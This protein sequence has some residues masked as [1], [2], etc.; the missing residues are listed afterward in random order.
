M[1]RRALV[2]S[3]GAI[4]LSGAAL[5]AD[6]PSYAPPPVYLPPPGL[7]LDRNLPRHQCR[8]PLRAD[9]RPKSPEAEMGTTPAFTAGLSMA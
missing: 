8:L 3:V 1:F 7:H 4:A 5:A 6:L 9:Q 2:A